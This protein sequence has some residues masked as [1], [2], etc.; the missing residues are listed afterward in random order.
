MSL[1]RRLIARLRGTSSGAGKRKKDDASIY[2][3]F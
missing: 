2:P 3:M 1:L